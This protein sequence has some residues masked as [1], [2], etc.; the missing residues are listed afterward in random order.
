MMHIRLRGLFVAVL[1]SG[2]AWA[3]ADEKPIDW[4]DVR[5]LAFE[6]QGWKDVK[7]PFDRL[8]GKA[9]GVVRPPVWSNSRNSAGLCARFVTDA[10]EIHARWTLTS[11]RLDMP[12]MPATGV[13]GLDLYARDDQGHWRWVAVGQP[14][15]AK[16]TKV[17]AQ[18]LKAGSREY[19]VYLPLYN[20]VS[21][22]EIG[23]PRGSKLDPAGPRAEG[24]RRPIVFYGT[25]ITHGGCASRPGMVHTAIVGRR[26][27][28]PVI[29][30]GFSGSGT[31]DPSMTDLLAE[32]DAAVYV[33]D[34]LPNMAAE[35][36][37]ARTEPLVKTLRK[38]R[39]DTPILFVEDRSYTDSTFLDA[40]R[41][42]NETSRAALKAAYERLRAEGIANLHYLEGESQVGDDG[43]GTVDGSH[44][45]DLGFMRMADVFTPALAPLVKVAVASPPAE[46]GAWLIG[47]A[48][49]EKR[50]GEPDLRVLDAR[51]RAA[52]DKG[53][54]PGAVWVDAKAVAATSTK[55]GALSD[56]AAWE[57]WI[58]PLGIGPKTKVLIYDANRQLDAARFWWLLR[59]LGVERVGLIDGNFPIWAKDGRPVTTAIPKVEPVPFPVVL[60]PD[61]LATRDQVLAALGSKSS[62]II[63]ARSEGEY[64]GTVKFSQRSGHVPTACSL[65]W[66]K[67][68][69]EDGR[70]LGEPSLRAKLAT[71]GVKPGDPVITH[72]QGGGRASVDAFV[73]ERLGFKTRNYYL[74]WSDWGNAADTPVTT[75]PKK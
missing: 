38:A 53:H 32:L 55:P 75:E 37:A 12:H 65:E 50:L 7:A 29:N 31:M 74:G 45:T 41:Q 13:S 47:F 57:R 34:C 58:A 11:D 6:G 19:L 2:A 9:E 27:D 36:V 43:E 73:F 63:D 23:V 48:D 44:P 72:C 62:T 5:S 10:T 68:V 17:L 56:R 61:V 39:P 16:N 3:K 33:I 67:F 70:F 46:K 28:V 26:L 60:R 35:D 42:R 59:Y 51:P 66:E 21:A 22:V 64:N 54:I 15:A 40:H 49:L 71:A 30:L 4:R 20:G 14:E 24:R 8:P 69:D 1:L 25:S 52:Y 18:G